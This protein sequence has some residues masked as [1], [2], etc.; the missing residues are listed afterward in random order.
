MGIVDLSDVPLID[1]HAHPFLNCRPETVEDWEELFTLY[2]SVHEMPPGKK[3]YTV[4]GRPATVLIA[5]LCRELAQIFRCPPEEALARRR[6]LAQ[7]LD[8]Y[9]GMLFRDIRLQGMVVDFAFPAPQRAD[10]RTCAGVP[11]WEVIRIE[12]VIDELWRQRLDWETFL[13]RY[14]DTLADRLKQA[15][16][17]GLK[18]IIAYRSGLSL[19]D[20]GF[21]GFKRAFTSACKGNQPVPKLVR[22]HL[23]LEAITLA[24][25][26]GKVFQIHTGFG[27]VDIKFDQVRPSLLFPVLKEKRYRG[28]PVVLVHAGYPWVEEA[29]CICRA[30]E[31]VY[32]DF[33]FLNPYVTFHLEEILGRI[34][35]IAPLN[36]IM[37]GSDGFN[38]PE[39]NWLGGRL[40]RRSLESLVGR[41][42]DEA[43]IGAD[44]GRWLAERVMYKNAEELYGLDL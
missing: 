41:L 4:D 12:P 42:V 3:T 13:K 40:A 1:A 2:K 39:M 37:Y 30:L 8:Q 26:Y 14:R 21:A 27:D 7:E 16:V 23:V 9:T 20:C 15:R 35:S 29:A 28:V 31:N 34:I 6:V 32:L 44:Y 10:F 5:L 18:S 36:K 25:E 17:V 43:V 24:G 19:E 11:V 33:S 38:V 22:D